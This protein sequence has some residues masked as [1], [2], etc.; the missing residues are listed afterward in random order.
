MADTSSYT[1][2]H[3][4][5][6]DEAGRGKGLQGR[7]APAKGAAMTPSPASNLAPYVS[8]YKHENTYRK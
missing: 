7:D 5:R 4:H 3:K 1:G 2:L 6:F 8:G